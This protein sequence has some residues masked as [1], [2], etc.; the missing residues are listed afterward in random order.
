MNTVKEELGDDVK[1]GIFKKFITDL[2]EKFEN[3]INSL[4]LFFILFKTPP[5]FTSEESKIK[6]R[7]I[8]NTLETF[9]DNNRDAISKRDY[10]HLNGKIKYT[11]R[12]FIDV[13]NLM[14]IDNRKYEKYLW[15]YLNN[16]TSILYVEKNDTPIEK[17]TSS[18]NGE[19][20]KDISL[21]HKNNIM[22]MAGI[23]KTT[24]TGELINNIIGSVEGC[25]GNGNDSELDMNTIL[26]RLISTNAISKIVSSVSKENKQKINKKEIL[27]SL[28]KMVGAMKKL[29]AD[30]NKAKEDE[31][32]DKIPNK[33]E[34]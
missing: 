10:S 30:M 13:K 11:D 7:K 22:D 33:E 17:S 18:Y 9:L 3:R 20:F 1:Y 28:E 16:I 15:E 6:V 12:I 21:E 5:D 25:V 23:D 31:T 27:S 26:T 24:P 32:L 4:S 14:S 8:V 2:I 34:E 19:T 29:D